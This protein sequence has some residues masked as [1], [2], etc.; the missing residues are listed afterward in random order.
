MKWY[1][2]AA[3]AGATL[4]AGALFA[5]NVPASEPAAAP[6]A[7]AAPAAPVTTPP[8]ADG[9]NAETWL[10]DGDRV[11]VAFSP[12]VEHF[13]NNPEYVDN[14]NLVDI[15]IETKYDTVWGA[16][17]TLFGLSVFKNSYGQPSQYLY[18]GQKWDLK[19]WLYAKVTAGLLHGYKGKYKTNIP[20]NNLGVAPAIIPA[21]GVQY[22]DVRA[23]AIVLGFSAL[24]F[25]VGY[26]F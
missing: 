10:R 3:A 14:T 23:E 2:I 25:T 5:Q 7:V 8:A 15:G 17:R 20:F 4:C 22:K 26:R 21:I 13:R 9:R 16:D 18:W 19:P 6:A 24:M 11:Y 1:S 12:Y